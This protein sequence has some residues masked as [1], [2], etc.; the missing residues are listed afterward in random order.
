MIFKNPTTPAE[1]IAEARRID[2]RRI[3]YAA[4][5][6]LTEGIVDE[7]PRCRHCLEICP[8]CD[9]EQ[10]CYPEPDLD[11]PETTGVINLHGKMEVY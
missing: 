6:C 7:L 5:Y 8:W 3:Q 9:C 10:E 1:I 4:A 2:A 11:T